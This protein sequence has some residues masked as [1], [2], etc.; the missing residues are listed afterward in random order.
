MRNPSTPPLTLSLPFPRGEGMRHR[1]VVFPADSS[2]SES[3][4]LADEQLLRVWGTRFEAVGHRVRAPQCPKI[5]DHAGAPQEGALTQTVNVVVVAGNLSGL[6]LRGDA[7]RSGGRNGEGGDAGGLC[8]AL[9][10]GNHTNRQNERE[11][12]GGKCSRKILFRSHSM[13]YRASLSTNGSRLRIAPPRSQMRERPALP[14]AGP[15]DQPSGSADQVGFTVLKIIGICEKKNGRV[16]Q[17][18]AIRQDT[19]PIEDTSILLWPE[20]EAEGYRARKPSRHYETFTPAARLGPQ[21]PLPP[22]RGRDAK[23]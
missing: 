21:R 3:R 12:G 5:I 1:S 15:G 10:L 23:E 8:A 16:S 6:I 4:S 13:S 9:V 2:V 19:F 11:H 20:W 17:R 7:E 22:R 18:R 14:A